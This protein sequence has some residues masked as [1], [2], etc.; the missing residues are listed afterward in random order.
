MGEAVKPEAVLEKWFGPE[1][2]REFPPDSIRAQWW[3]KNNSFDAELRRDYGSA[4]EQGVSGELESWRSTALGCV[5]LIVLFDQFARNIHRG[6]AE[7]YRYDPLAVELSKT[8]IEEG[9]DQ[10]IGF[11]ERLFVY[12][13]LMHAESLQDQKQC[14]E[15]IDE[16]ADEATDPAKSIFSSN[17]KYAYQ[18]KEIVARF[19]RFPHRNAILGR[20]S[21]PEELEFLRQPGSSF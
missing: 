21:T 2:S 20:D 17:L 18:H 10:K 19:G 15:K 11:F 4:L 16:L 7:M 6:K 13:P 14:I 8:M 3:A 9:S 1:S 12:M 5:A